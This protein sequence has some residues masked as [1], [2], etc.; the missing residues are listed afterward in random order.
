VHSTEAVTLQ[1]M[2][3]RYQISLPPKLPHTP[4]NDFKYSLDAF[5]SATPPE[6]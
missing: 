5:Q 6:Q 2:I 3:D 4:E 1:Y